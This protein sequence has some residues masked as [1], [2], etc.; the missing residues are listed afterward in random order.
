MGAAGGL[1]GAQEGI[2]FE[3]LS[4]AVSGVSLYVTP[5][6]C[7]CWRPLPGIGGG[8]EYIEK[9]S[10][11]ADEGWY[12]RLRISVVKTA[13]YNKKPSFMLRKFKYLDVD[14]NIILK[15]ILKLWDGWM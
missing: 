1:S 6:R 8:N 12:S 2:Y 13:S 7:A 11:T 14:G 5:P 9:Q 3:N 15:W 10:W 4:L